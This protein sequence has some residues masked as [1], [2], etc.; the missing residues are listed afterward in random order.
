[1]RTWT[2]TSS[3]LFLAAVSV[4]P[5]R[6]LSGASERQVGDANRARPAAEVRLMDEPLAAAPA[7]ALAAVPV[8][9]ATQPAAAPASHV[10]VSD[11][12]TVEIHANEANLA[13]IL[14]MLSVQMQKNIIASKDVRGTI[15]ANLYGVTLKEALEAVLK[16]N[17]YGYREKGNFI[18]VYSDKEL[19]EIEKN[20]R[21]TSVEVFRLHYTPVAVASSVIKP[22][23]GENSE[24]SMT[25]AAI[26]GIDSKDTGGASHATED[27][28][29]VRAYP[30][31]LEKIRKVLK[32]L[33]RR[34]QQIL[35]EATII[36]ARLSENNNLGIDFAVLGGVDFAGLTGG[37][38]SSVDQALS[39]RVLN[40]SL[41]DGNRFGGGMTG[42]TQNVPQKGGLKVGF[43]SNNIAVFLQALEATTDAAVLANP[44]VLT[45]NKQLGEVLVGRE[46]GYLTTAVTETSTVQ[47]VQ[48]LQTGTRLI[49]R[50][51]IAEDGYI[52][53]EIHPED[54]DG[55]VINGLPSKTTT[56][57]TTNIMVKDGHTI[58]IGGL[59]REGSATGR[60]QVPGLGNLPLVG[61]LFR[62]Q[63]DTTT[64]E[65][66]IILLT[67]HIVK[68]DQAYA[69]ASAEQL[70][71][72]EKLRVGVRRGMMFFGRERLAEGSYEKALAEMRKPNP[73]RQKALWYLDCATNL[74]PLFLEAIRMKE[75]LTGHQISSVDN[76]SIRHFL[77][78][79][80][81]ADR[82]ATVQAPARMPQREALASP[83]TQ[84]AMALAAPA[85]Q[86]ALALAC[87][88][89]QPAHPAPQ[90]PTLL[91]RSLAAAKTLLKSPPAT[92]PASQEHSVEDMVVT[93]LPTDIIEVEGP[94]LDEGKE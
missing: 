61:P 75:N 53:M 24:I 44:K 41:A 71:D 22:L 91:E 18:Y 78:K 82:P 84:P 7:P 28:L 19:K 89:T 29:V 30:E 9:P 79:Q 51:Y 34:P 86:P 32:D 47:T 80:V 26:A 74:N 3:L 21:Q 69:E 93:E 81:L 56:E 72:M 27:L 17:G 67:P 76:S 66:V 33:D 11:A 94:A 20:E 58:V 62:S 4:Y 31:N 14:K 10:S 73:D 5:G 83:A 40:T 37:G 70:K 54:S 23:L 39:G 35:V 52:R 65:E 8:L 50:P 48:F 64:R 2:R 25:P 13:E 38:A 43:V 90:N 68:N 6:A 57:V 16:P 45:L 88:A 1:M 63:E 55:K 59:F 77:T 60:S 15:T 36:S 85:T 46:D 42:F 12:G 49:F 87:P 92:Q